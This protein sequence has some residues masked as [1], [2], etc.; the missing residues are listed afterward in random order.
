MNRLTAWSVCCLLCLLVWRQGLAIE[1]IQISIGNWSTDELAA[2]GFG[3]DIGLSASGLRLDAHADRLTLPPPA[4]QID[5][6]SLHCDEAR[7]SS[8]RVRCDSGTLKFTHP[9]LGTQN[10]AFS[11]ESQPDS[12]RHRLNLTGLKLAEGSLSLAATSLQ[13]AWKLE[14][15]A[16]QVSLAA[17]SQWLRPWLSPEQSAVLANWDHQGQLNIQARVNGQEAK[18]SEIEL[19]LKGW[20]LGFSNMEGNNVAE[21]L[22]ADWQFAAERVSQQWQWRSRLDVN[23]GQSYTEPVFLDFGATPLSLN[24]RGQWE[25]QTGTLQVEQIDFDQQSVLAASGLLTLQNNVL[26]RLELSTEP[27]GLAALYPVWLQPFLLDNAAGKMETAGSVALDFKLNNGDYQLQVEADDVS[28]VDQD[29]RFSLTGLNGRLGWTDADITL[30]S[31]VSWQQAQVYAVPIGAAELKAQSRASGLVLQDSLNLPVLDGELAVNAFSLQQNEDKRVD[32]TFEGL[33]T[34]ISMEA[35]SEALGWPLLH[36]KLSGVIPRVS[37]S[38]QEVGVDGALQVKLFDGVTVIRDLRLT[39]PL[40]AIPQLYANIDVDNIDLELLTR[41]FDFGRITGRLDGQVHN[42]RL[43]NWQP[44]RFDATFAT[45]EQDPGKRRISQKAVDNLTEIGGGAAGALS[46][47][48][49]RF[50]EDF[51][52]QRLGISCRLRNEVCEMAGVEEA[53]QGY[54]IVK[55]GGGL[56]P[57]INVVGYTRRV[58]W[59]DLIERLKAVSES[60]GPVIE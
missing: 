30:D 5:N 41:T 60:S 44:V 59:T 35:L 57:W 52:Y 36:G 10:L 47:S 2:Q 26:T 27:A 40:G 19:K 33:L 37:Y 7:F 18:L 54:Y 42:L 23:G 46:R 24:A 39:T 6:V 50:F 55:G 1:D 51:S 9:Q 29:E 13:A 8:G 21:A 56:P 34:P 22:A 14:L 15:Q 53:E 43:A 3:L 45:P 28:V 38:R 11:L 49:L 48:F 12:E 17:L 31:A 4:G 25:Q 58:D 16:E 20:D 32:W